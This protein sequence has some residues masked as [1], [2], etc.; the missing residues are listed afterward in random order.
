MSTYNRET[1]NNG[2]FHKMEVYFSP[3]RNI[4]SRE[5]EADSGSA[6]STGTQTGMEA[7]ASMSRLAF[8]CPGLWSPVI[9]LYSRFR[10]KEQRWGYRG[11][12]FLMESS[13]VNICLHLVSQNSVT[14]PHETVRETGVCSLTWLWWL[15]QKCVLR[16]S[17]RTR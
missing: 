10:R 13:P 1:P 3:V 15:F 16:S 4:Q 8:G 14:W 7:W 2:S 9:T 5:S 12:D 6:V 17:C 11:K